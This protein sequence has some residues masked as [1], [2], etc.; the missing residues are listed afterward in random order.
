MGATVTALDATLG[1]GDTLEPAT[2]LVDGVTDVLNNTLA[3]LVGGTFTPN[4]PN[5]LD[6]AD[7]F[8]GSITNP[9]GSSLAPSLD[10]LLSDTPMMSALSRSFSLG[11]SNSPTADI[12]AGVNQ[13]VDYLTD[14]VAYLVDNLGGDALPLGQVLDGL[15]LGAAGDG[16]MAVDGPVGE[17]LAELLNPEGAIGSLTAP[18]GPIGSLLAPEGPVGELLASG[19]AVAELLGNSGVVGN[20]V[21]GD[22]VVSGT[23]SSL[24]GTREG[25]PADGTA[26]LDPTSGLFATLLP[27][28]QGLPVVAD[29]G[30][31]E[32]LAPATALVDNLTNGVSHALAPMLGSEFTADNPNELDGVDELVVSVTGGAGDLLS[33]IADGLLG[34]GT[35]DAALGQINT[36]VDFL[37]DGLA[38]IGASLMDGQLFGDLL[39]GSGVVGGPVSGDGANLLQPAADLVSALTEGLDGL[40][41]VGEL[42]ALMPV[43]ELV[44]GLTG[45]VSDVLAPVLGGSFEAD[46]PN[47]LDGVDTLVS[48]VTGGVGDLL[49][50]VTEQLLGE[51]T[52]DSVLASV[53]TQ[54]DYVTDGVSHLVGSLTDGELLGG[55][56]GGDALGGDLLGGGLLDGVLGEEGLVGG[57]LGG[58]ALGGDLL[59]GDLLDGVLGEEGLVGGLLG[60]DA[61]GG[62][63]LGGGLLDGV[64][65]EEGLVGGLLG[66][67][68][69]GGD[70][71]GG[72]LLDGV[73]GEEGLVGGLLG[74]DALGGDLLGGDLL[75]GVL[76]E[77][78]L[79]GGLLGGDAL[80]GDLLGGDLVGG[81][82]GEEGL[83]GGLLGGDALGGDLLGGDLVGGLLGEEGVVGG[84]LDT[85]AGGDGLLGSLLGSD[86][87]L[88][89]PLSSSGGAG[90]AAPQALAPVTN[91]LGGLLG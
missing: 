32:A 8:V 35:L 77:E 62:D 10:A 42:N 23:L 21:G 26:A 54:V 33:P 14:G 70:L 24:L 40:P 68:A 25:A 66:G 48:S 13:Q 55:L 5:A 38:D 45:T 17:L 73:L 83:V 9:L 76:G 37:T 64:L 86:G 67:D 60:G 36:Q 75:D 50:P 74:D 84:V 46:N 3:P 89:A 1:L 41:V 90:D 27:T 79:V 16:L 15:G 56:L 30:L 12:I 47:E 78:G 91:L 22:G 71:L 2:E 61:L 72:G 11:S 88:L 87:G 82:L 31:G 19:G 28:V 51:G 58:D 6:P 20:L 34:E 52:L 39:G 43:S 18:E 85:V 7:N 29:V 81:L 69:L 65:G 59:G 44:D 53:N 80:G 49:S 57:L 63:L 4:N